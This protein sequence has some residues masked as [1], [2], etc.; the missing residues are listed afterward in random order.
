[1]NIIQDNSFLVL[2]LDTAAPQKDIHRRAR[3]LSSLLKID[4]EGEYARD[5]PLIT[6][7]RTEESVKHALQRLSSPTKKILD[8]FFWFE[9]ASP[10]DEKAFECI[11][12]E[13]YREAIAIWS[14]EAGTSAKG[15]IAKRNLAILYGALLLSHDSKSYLSKSVQ[16]WKELLDDDK[17]WASFTKL[18][19][20]NDDSGTS[21]SVIDDFRKDVPKLLS[22]FYT[23]I[24]KVHND[25]QYTL[26]FNESF[27]IKGAEVQKDLELIFESINNSA[28]QL[29]ALNISEDEK[30]T[31]EEIEDLKRL[32]RELR[33]DF[34][35]LKEVGLYDDSQSKQMRD[36]AAESIRT[37]TLDLYNNLNESRK[38]MS[39]LK[40][41]IDICGTP[42]TRAK[43]MKDMD[44]LR[45]NISNERVS[46]PINQLVDDEKYEDALA[47]VEDEMPKHETNSDLQTYF[48]NRI[49]TCVTSIAARDMKAANELTDKGKFADAAPI[50]AKVRDLILK[51]IEYFNIDQDALQNLIS[52][53]EL[54]SADLKNADLEKIDEYRNDIKAKAKEIFED[55]FEEYILIMLVDASIYANLSTQVGSIRRKA[56][57][58]NWAWGIAIAIFLLIAGSSGSSD[59]SNTSSDSG[60]SSSAFSVCKGEY[61]SLKSQLEA[62]E[63]QMDSSD[64]DSYNAMVPRQNELVGQLNAKRDECNSLQ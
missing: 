4:E 25:N 18:Y 55:Q 27:G 47:M 28:E 1:M 51:Y 21:D 6:P 42:G 13:D 32:I 2:G 23:A 38:S 45:S 26:A 50:F 54:M 29:E 5:I 15:L 44:D 10:S 52:D 3:E 40:V 41:A 33:R 14:G 64:P 9:L 17:F 24:S 7:N 48:H 43:L 53:L 49:K 22:D 59:S 60:S 58:K 63:A 8:Y 37:V 34:M 31:D 61:D 11:K 16:I 46:K 36:K 19:R 20:L 30:I 56:A 39:L 57:W 12:Y 62:V 35:K